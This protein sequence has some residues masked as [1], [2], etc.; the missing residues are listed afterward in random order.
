MVTIVRIFTND[1]LYYQ[2]LDKDG[3]KYFESP[4]KNAEAAA[5]AYDY[6]GGKMPRHITNEFSGS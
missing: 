5:S 3:D 6:L 2:V 1:G 4:T